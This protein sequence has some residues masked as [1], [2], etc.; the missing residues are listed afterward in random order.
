MAGEGGRFRNW[1]ARRDAARKLSVTDAQI[2]SY[3]KCIGNSAVSKLTYKQ[4]GSGDFMERLSEDR[5]AS[6]TIVPTSN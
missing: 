6:C 1:R 2:E 3:C 4:I 5:R